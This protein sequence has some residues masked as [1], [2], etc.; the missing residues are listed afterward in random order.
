MMRATHT[1]FYI[2]LGI[3]VITW[4]G[5][6]VVWLVH[7]CVPWLPF[8]SDFGCGPTRWFFGIGMTSAALIVIPA[9]WEYGDAVYLALKRA[10]VDAGWRWKLEFWGIVSS[11]G[12]IGVACNPWDLRPLIHELSA[13]G[14]FL[15]GLIFNSIANKLLKKLGGISVS[16]ASVYVGFAS[17]VLMVVFIGIGVGDL[18]TAGH[19]DSTTF[20]NHAF[21]SIRTDFQQYCLAAPGTLHADWRVNLGAFFEWIMLICIVAPAF[22][23]L[24]GAFSAMSLAAARYSSEALL[25]NVS[26]STTNSAQE[27]E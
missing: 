12:I 7:G 4:V 11:L 5:S 25:A 3:A 22:F 24:H 1:C 14:I 6:Y 15:G 9:Y 10:G 16:N 8:V 21:A 18:S 17:F 13:Y 26:A 19:V 27:V 23:K 20:L 2:G